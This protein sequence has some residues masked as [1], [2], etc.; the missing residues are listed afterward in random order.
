MR[1][2][3]ETLRLVV[4]RRKLLDYA[5]VQHAN[6]QISWKKGLRRVL[7]V[8]FLALLLVEW[9][10]H[11]LAFAH[12]Y[13]DDGAAVQSQ[14][15]GHEDPCK[16]LIQ[17][18]DGTRPDQS[19]PKFAHLL[20]YGAFGDGLFPVRRWIDLHKDPRLRRR[21]LHPLVRPSDPLFH[22]PEIS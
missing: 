19:A 17:C 8:A 16:T 12:A 21:P 5:L 1:S 13:S 9:G 15:N 7:A 2:S 6:R 3:P 4:R 10:S 22:P 18:S 11:N 20:Q 14:D